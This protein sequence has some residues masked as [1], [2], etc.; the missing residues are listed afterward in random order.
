MLDDAN[1]AHTQDVN[2]CTCVTFPI[3]ERFCK[4][5]PGQNKFHVESWGRALVYRR[6]F[7][8]FGRTGRLVR[9]DQIKAMVG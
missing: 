7:N 1:A 9:R 6:D 8:F 4:M 2:E 3:L 5:K